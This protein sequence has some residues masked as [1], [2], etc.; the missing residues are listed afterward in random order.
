MNRKW[1]TLSAIVLATVVLVILGVRSWRHGRIH[2][3]TDNAY[4]GGDVTTVSS[5]VA[6]T[7]VRVAVAEHQR[8]R[9]G[10]L[11]AELDPRDFDQALARERASLAAA[12]AALDLQRARIEG[13]RAR[14]EAARA[15]ADLARA[16]LERFRSLEEKGST[17]RRRYEQARAAARVARAQVEAARRAL[18]AEEAALAVE[19]TRVDR[20]RAA[21]ESA[22]LRRSYCTIVAPCDGVV[23]N[24]SA[25]PG[26]VVAPGQPLCRIAQLDPAHVWVDANFKET[27]LERVRVG[28]P[29]RIRID[30]GGDREYRGHVASLDAG[31]GAAFSLLPP[32][33]A[34]GNWV[35]VV[36]RLPVRIRFD[37]AVPENVLRLGLSCHVTVDTRGRA[38][39][40][41]GER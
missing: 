11:V 31:T 6:G 38:G 7:I 34:T 17:A 18:A 5:R 1:L 16:D 14:L 21:V 33:N 22:E 37:E 10:D 40:E 8:V 23:A 30:A 2:P 15:Q 12:Q 19:R 41:P 36:Q 28:Q 3:S 35:K 26:Q 9:S 32:E 25:L 20:A 4:I 24:K 39:E 13:A 27:Q 29:A